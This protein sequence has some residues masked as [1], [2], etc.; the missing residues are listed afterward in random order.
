MAFRLFHEFCP[1]L[2]EQETRTVT[3]LPGADLG[4]PPGE[5]ALLEMFCDEPD[6]DCRRVLFSVF[7]LSCKRMDA[8]ITWGWEDLEHYR[9][10]M[11]YGSRE[12][13]EILR[14]P[15]LNPGSPTADYAAALLALVREIVVA[16]KAFARR[17]QRHYNLFRNKIDGGSAMDSRKPEISLS[18]SQTAYDSQAERVY[19]EPVG[20]L[21]TAGEPGATVDPNPQ[22]LGKGHVKTKKK[23]KDQKKS[24]TKNRRK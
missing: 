24:R 19:D 13:A 2:A 3:I 10:W 20:R 11:T 22:S 12:D 16:D 21:L 8:V 5:Y 17:I 23:R 18:A 9:R 7:S 6:C 14:G 4:I 15:S 1:D